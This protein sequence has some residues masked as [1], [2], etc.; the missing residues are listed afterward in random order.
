MR[1][2]RRVVVGLLAGAIVAT[3]CGGSASNNGSASKPKPVD[4][5]VLTKAADATTAQHSARIAVTMNVAGM[6]KDGAVSFDGTA[7]FDTGN[8]EF[9]VQATGALAEQLSEPVTVRVVD[10]GPYVQVPESQRSHLGVTTAWAK[11]SADALG[12]GSGANPLGGFANITDPHGMLAFLK[13]TGSDVTALGSETRDGVHTTHY[14]GVVDFAHLIQ[15]QK[16]AH[17]KDAQ[18]GL[19]M[20]A[21]FAGGNIRFPIDVYVDNDGRVREMH[22]TWDLSSI[23]SG[24][25]SAFG[26]TT[27]STT[28]PLKAVLEATLKV[29]DFGLPVHVEAPPADQVSDLP[30]GEQLFGGDGS[31][32]GG[33][34]ND[35]PDSSGSS[36]STDAT[37]GKSCSA[38]KLAV[39]QT[40]VAAYRAQHGDNAQ[41]TLQDLVTAGILK[42][43][44]GMQL[45]YSGGAASYGA[46]C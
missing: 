22:I 41:P 1:T 11:A 3:A 31:A 19:G 44:A 35:T 21:L 33:W 23:L 26:A 10:K 38:Q 9:T 45:S 36:P 28:A 14:R 27:S 42:D 15:Q 25:G 13:A 46:S 30:D 37:A 8:G 4:A 20:L 39:L 24:L 6:G 17:S 12:L 43:T 34:G 16:G 40:A 7:D 18:L 2:N 29:S 32:S 5:A